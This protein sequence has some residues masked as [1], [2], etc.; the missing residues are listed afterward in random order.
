MASQSRHLGIAIDRTAAEVYAFVSDPVNLPRWAAG[1]GSS[2]EL[3]E[4]Q[5]IADSPMGRVAVAFVEPNDYGVVDHRV[6]LPGG[7]TFYN[8]MRVIADAGSCDVVFTLR[9]RPGMADEEFDRDADAV[10]TDLATLKRLL[11]TP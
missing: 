4:G 6:T 1:L 3:I 10:A 5:W 7:E 8:P 2:V 9:R 11:E